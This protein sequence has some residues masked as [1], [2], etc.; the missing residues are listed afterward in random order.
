MLDSPNR[1]TK[2]QLDE[3]TTIYVA[4]H[5][6]LAGSAI[7]RALQKRGFRNIITRTHK[8]LDLT[9]PELVDA[10]FDQVRPEIVFIEAA[11]VGG[12]KAND[13][14]PADF[15]M[16]NIAIEY[17]IIHAAHK[18]NVKKLLYPGSSC[19]YPREC[20]QPIKE[21]YLLTGPLEKTNEPFAVAKI[22]GIKMCEAMN[23]QYGHHFLPV[24][25][26]NL[27][28]PGDSFDLANSHVLP[29]IIR[30]V[31]E[32]KLNHVP[33]L[34]LWGTGTPRREFLYSD[35]LAEA[36]IHLLLDTDEKELTNIG[37]GSDVT[38]KELAQLIARIVEYDGDI[39]F[40]HIHPDGTP[41]KKLDVSKI[42]A[43]G[44]KARISLEEGL[45]RSYQAYL[46]TLA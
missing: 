7:C 11:K 25:P 6:G 34:T 4:G 32:A 21:S 27:Y 15:I 38:I 22:A 28:G 13:T 5:T 31:H 2:M 40:D 20:P 14:Y 43:L 8:E 44:W 23:K 19:I 35:D 18:Y 12:I 37:T 9:K 16:Q 45:C 41:Q 36:C 1:S 24:M 17:A 33:K 3:N 10:F 29:A 42:H 26:T 46:D 30:R 39:E